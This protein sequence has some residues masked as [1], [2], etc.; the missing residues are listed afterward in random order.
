MSR[1]KDMQKS[2]V[3]AHEAYEGSSDLAVRLLAQGKRYSTGNVHIDSCQEYV[4]SVLSRAWF[5]RRWPA[6]H[7]YVQHKSGGN[8]YGYRLGQHQGRITLPVFARTER[9]IL[10]EI[11]HVLTPG[12]YASHGPEWAGVYLELVRYMVGKDAAAQV[13]DRFKQGR[14]RW[15]KKAVPKA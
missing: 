7:I 4:D 8:A 9:I 12:K 3:Y 10:H 6:V 1:P 11:A 14:V 13:R 15:N 5:V 2:R